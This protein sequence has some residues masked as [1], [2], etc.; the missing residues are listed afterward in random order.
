[1]IPDYN[2]E[3]VSIDVRVYAWEEIEMP[4]PLPEDPP[5]FEWVPMQVNIDGDIWHECVPEPATLALM[6]FGGLALLRCRR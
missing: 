3:W 1:M 6:L 4:G 5:M 2:P